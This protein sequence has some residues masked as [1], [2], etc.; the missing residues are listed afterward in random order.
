MNAYF[1]SI[2]L[3]VAISHFLLL[4]TGELGGEHTKQ[5]LRYLYGLILLLTIF[6]PLHT[7]IQGIS[8][9]VDTIHS[10][11]TTEESFDTDPVDAVTDSTYRYVADSWITY[12][13]ENY[14][15]NPEDIRITIYTDEDDAMEH[16]EIGLRN[17]YYAHRQTIAE[18]LQEMTELPITVQGW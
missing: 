1:R 13:A 12:I 6:A 14:A 17:C 4:L 9:I 3:T 5:F 7:G 15:M 8:T 11:F 16:V 10:I 2:L 18:N